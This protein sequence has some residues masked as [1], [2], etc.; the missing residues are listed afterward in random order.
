MDREVANE[1]SRQ[2]VEAAGQTPEAQALIALGWHVVSPYGYS[3]PSG[4]TIGRY[5][6]DGVW[7]TVLWEG[8]HIHGRFKNPLTAARHHAKRQGQP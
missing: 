5:R 8:T 4:W 2:W 1:A 7:E 3:H 6:T